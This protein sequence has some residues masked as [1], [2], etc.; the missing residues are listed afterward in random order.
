MEYKKVERVKCDDEVMRGWGISSRRLIGCVSKQD[1]SRE[2]WSR[3]EERIY[4]TTNYY[5][6][7]DF[8][9]RFLDS[10]AD[11]Y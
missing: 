6:I 11:P 10:R 8:A 4:S 5:Q 9:Y 2:S 3:A 1:R 7:S